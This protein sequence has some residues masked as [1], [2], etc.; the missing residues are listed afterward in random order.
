VEMINLRLRAK[1][2]EPVA[3]HKQMEEPPSETEL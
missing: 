2:A 3:L 1:P